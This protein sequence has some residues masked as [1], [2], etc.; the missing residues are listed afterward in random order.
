MPVAS[1]PG[2]SAPIP[3]DQEAELPQAFKVQGVIDL[4]ERTRNGILL[5]LPIWLVLMQ[6]DHYMAR[7]PLFVLG[8]AGVLLVITCARWRLQ[9]DLRPLLLRHFQRTLVAFRTISLLH[10][11]YW[12]VL[13][14]IVFTAPDAEHARWLMMMSTVGI[15]AGGI[16]IVA[17][18]DVLPRVYP[19][20]LL[21]P[22]FVALMTKIDANN[23]SVCGLIIVVFAY[24][25]AVKNVV[26]RDY[27]ARQRG[28]ALLEQRAREL[29]MLSRTDVLTQVPNRLEFQER[30]NIAWRDARRRNEPVSV[31]MVDLDHFK[32]V[33]DTHGHPF[34]DLCLQAA[35]QALIRAVRRPGDLVA[36]FGGEEFIVLM[37]N[38]AEEGARA[39]AERMLEHVAQTEVQDGEHRVHLSCSIGVASCVP[40]TQGSH[41]GL[42]RAADE[43]LYAAKQAGRARVVCAG[44]K[45]PA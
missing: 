20:A 3:R 19:L 40:Q 24:A 9:R 37:P 29:E 31:A 1:T 34:G 4:S 16:V 45:M 43:V 28:Q 38:T 11:L 18:D 35:A 32:Q 15:T 22:S 41:E 30:L 39:V 8:N 14:A 10:N 2:L 21:G 7:H 23:L 26:S 36:R 42:V 17:I 12:G 25:Q 27:W 5:Y 44:D 33:N 6:A 13:C